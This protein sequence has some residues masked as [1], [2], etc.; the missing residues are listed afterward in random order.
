M[1]IQDFVINQFGEEKGKVINDHQKIWFE[2]IVAN[3][4]GKS[5][6]Q[7]N[8]LIKTILPRIALYN[9]LIELQYP[10]DEAFLKIKDYLFNF[11]GKDMNNQLRKIEKLPGFFSLF[12]SKMYKE[13]STNDNWN[14]EIIE[15]KRDII[16]YNIK[17]CLWYDACKE[18]GCPE[19][20]RIFCDVDH[21]IYGNMKKVDFERNGTIGSGSELCDFKYIR[22]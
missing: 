2:R 12:R 21:I 13:V 4:N 10:K 22:K 15:N 11:V 7:T 6:N 9:A 1:T 8:T 5:Q 18:N 20:C 16:A 17:K 14:V 3:I 19:L